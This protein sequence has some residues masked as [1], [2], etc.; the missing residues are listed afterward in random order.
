MSRA[1]AS[2]VVEPDLI[3]VAGNYAGS[4]DVQAQVFGDAE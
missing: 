2:P 1:N 3:T 4:V